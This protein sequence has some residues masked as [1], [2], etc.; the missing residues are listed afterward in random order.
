MTTI[1][2]SNTQA[3]HDGQ[4]DADHAPVVIG[5]RTVDN[6]AFAC[7]EHNGLQKHR[8]QDGGA[9]ACRR[10]HGGVGKRGQKASLAAVSG[11]QGHHGAVGRIEAGIAHCIEEVEGY[12]DPYHLHKIIGGLRII[13]AGRHKKKN[14]GYG[15]DRHRQQQVGPCLAGRRTGIVDQL[16]HKNISGNDKDCGNDGQHHGKDAELLIGQTDDVRIVTGKIGAENRIG[17]HGAQRRQEITDQHLLQLYLRG[18]DLCL[19]C[20]VFKKSVHLLS[21]S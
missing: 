1:L 7:H 21:P 5:S 12:G 15:H 17:Q 20:R 19:Q 4:N 9:Y 16:A 18:S 6:A 2:Q 3:R 14:D 10:H 11:G 13:S 8:H